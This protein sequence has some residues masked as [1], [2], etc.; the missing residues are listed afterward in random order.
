MKKILPLFLL[1]MWYVQLVHDTENDRYRWMAW[2]KQLNPT[3]VMV[4]EKSFH[5]RPQAVDDWKEFSKKKGIAEYKL[6]NP[7][8]KEQRGLSDETD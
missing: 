4:S 2:D 6:L 5:G 7:P 3:S 1:A 8:F